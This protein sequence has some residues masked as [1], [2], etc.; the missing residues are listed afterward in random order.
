MKLPY[1]FAYDDIGNVSID[2]QK[3]NTVRMIY[4]QY[5]RQPFRSCGNT[6]PVQP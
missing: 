5:V 2:E 3:A 1:G 4:R 6:L